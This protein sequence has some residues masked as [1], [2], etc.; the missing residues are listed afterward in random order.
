MYVREYGYN[1]K[2]RML[3]QQEP[4]DGWPVEWHGVAGGE[5]V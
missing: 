2:D 5:I 1:D 4:V 3:V